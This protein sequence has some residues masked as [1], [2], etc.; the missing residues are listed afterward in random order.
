MANDAYLN[1]YYCLLVKDGRLITKTFHGFYDKFFYFNQRNGRDYEAI[2]VDINGVY[3]IEHYNRQNKSIPL[4]RQMIVRIKTVKT[5]LYKNHC[6]VVYTQSKDERSTEV[7]SLLLNGNAKSFTQP[8]TRTYSH[9]LTD[10]D[11]LL[12]QNISNNEIYNTLFKTSGG[13]YHSKSLSDE[14]RN[15]NKSKTESNN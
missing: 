10:V 1:R 9:V 4:L 11:C 6:Y 13:L 3:S 14:P 7:E 2:R 5:G 12:F 15:I 8:C